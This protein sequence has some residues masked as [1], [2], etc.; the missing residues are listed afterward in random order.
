MGFGFGFVYFCFVFLGAG[1]GEIDFCAE[2]IQ[3]CSLSM[4]HVFHILPTEGFNQM[5]EKFQL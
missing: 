2:N 4:T 1:G 5:Q 3:K